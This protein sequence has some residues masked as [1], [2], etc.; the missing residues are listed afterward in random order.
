MRMLSQPQRHRGHRGGTENSSVPP[1]CPLCL[2]GEI[3]L[4]YTH[5]ALTRH[6]APSLIKTALALLLLLLASFVARA[7]VA[8]AA[9]AGDELVVEG[10]LSGDVF[11]VGRA[12]R[13]RGEVKN[14]VLAFG[15]DVVVEGRV[16]GD[17]AA[18]GGSVVQL[19]GSHVGRDVMGIG[20]DQRRGAG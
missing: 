17:V 19:D 15:G 7:Q 12:V 10:G 8:D 11:G 18:I 5:A 20:G 16:E 14:G 13:V 3:N 4:P 2:C 1:L 9:R 6:A